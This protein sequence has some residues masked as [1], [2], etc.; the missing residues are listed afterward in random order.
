MTESYAF[1]HEIF[2]YIYIYIYMGWIQVTP[3]VTPSNVTPINIFL[4]DV[5]FDRS[6]IELHYLCIFF[7]LTKFQGD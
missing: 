7:M 2:A 4:L 3:G 6:T 5:N 1:S